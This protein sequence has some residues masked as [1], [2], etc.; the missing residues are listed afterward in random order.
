MARTGY[1]VSQIK[2]LMENIEECYNNLGTTVQNGWEPVK[3]ALKANWVGEDEQDYESGLADRISSMYVSTYNLAQNA[4][5][6][7]YNLADSWYKFQQGN[8]IFGTAAT[9]STFGL[10]QITLTQNDKVVEATIE[11]IGD[12]VD[13]GLVSESSAGT[14]KEAL[15]TYK[16]SVQSKI[17]EMIDSITVDTAFYG[18]Q[19]TSIKS[20]VDKVG[21]AMGEVV[22]AIK[23]L[24]D[25]VDQLA[26]SQYSTASTTFTG[27]IDTAKSN[28]ESELESGLGDTRWQ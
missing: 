7:I 26:D 1:N 22:T 23:D 3:T 15:S 16:T 21:T 25:A 4:L 13:R 8:K 11:S 20:F 18:E 19:S 28:V 24:N 6:I 9:D 17:A 12:D 27:D 10:E 2:T 14:I 5:G